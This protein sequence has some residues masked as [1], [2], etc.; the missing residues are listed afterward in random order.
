LFLPFLKRKA[1]PHRSKSFIFAL[2]LVPAMTSAVM[3]LS[4]VTCEDDDDEDVAEMRR[5]WKWAPD[6]G[7]PPPL[8]EKP[9]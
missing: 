3:P 8:L 4:A 1:P 6:I 7:F 5:G 9:I 2:A